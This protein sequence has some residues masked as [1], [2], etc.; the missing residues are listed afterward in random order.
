MSESSMRT[1]V[2]EVLRPWDAVAVENSAL[3]GTPDIE[4]MLGWLELKCLDAWPK[5][6]EVGQP[7]LIP[8]Y[9]PQQRVWLLRRTRKGGVAVL[10]LKVG[11]SEWLLF[12]GWTAARLVGRVSA[13]RLR[14]EAYRHWLTTKDMAKDLPT[15]LTEAPISRD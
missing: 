5:H 12:D 9:T 10:L 2:L 14:E 13:T 3:P 4:C 6:K 15:Q 8:H 11:A 1:T 7:V